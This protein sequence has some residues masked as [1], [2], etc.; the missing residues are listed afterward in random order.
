MVDRS[1]RETNDET[2][3]FYRVL[4]SRRDVRGQFLPD[5]VDPAALARILLAAHHAPSVGLSQPWNFILVRDRAVRTRVHQAFC[6]ARAGEEALF[7]GKHRAAYRDLKLEGI[8][9]APLNICVTCDRGRDGPVVLGRT[10]QPDTDLYSSACAVQNLWLAARA[11][12]LGVGWVSIVEPARLVDILGLP[13]QVV[14]LAYLCIG[15]VAWFHERPELEV[16]GWRRRLPVADLVFGDTWGQSD[17]DD[18]LRAAL[19]ALADWP[20]SAVA[21]SSSW[22]PAS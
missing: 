17:G 10:R 14:P 18:D 4:F 20:A 1:E 8:L 15:H 5:P 13:E 7:E 2:A 3:D 21:E 12:G 6:E 11:E 22:P 16:K 9:D 19:A